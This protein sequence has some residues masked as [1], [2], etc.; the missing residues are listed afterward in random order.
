MRH[1]CMFPPLQLGHAARHFATAAA[2]VPTAAFLPR[3]KEIAPGATI[4]EL[5]RPAANVFYAD[6]S[7]I[8]SMLESTARI[9]ALLRP[10]RWGKTT[11]LQMVG[12]YYDVAN[13]HKPVIPL[14]AATRL[15]R[16]PFPS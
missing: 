3:L 6:K 4:A 13:K 15:G 1:Y 8:L 2:A 11:V 9:I 10:Q 7:H 5:A 14:R 16:I 12:A